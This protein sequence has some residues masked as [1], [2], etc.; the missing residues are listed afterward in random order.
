MTRDLSLSGDEGF[1]LG[2][3][4]VS[5]MTRLERK[6]AAS[7]EWITGEYQRMNGHGRAWKAPVKKESRRK[8][9]DVSD[10]DISIVSAPQQA[11]CSKSGRVRLIGRPSGMVGLK[12]TTR[13]QLPSTPEIPRD[14]GMLCAKY[15]ARSA[16]CASLY[17]ALHGGV[18][19]SLGSDDARL[20]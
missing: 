18:R 16:L 15:A 20:L 17:I 7:S 12:M 2:C 13:T 4:L 19:C 1:G 11:G 14:S 8:R 3:L 10:G 9:L 6:D 5:R